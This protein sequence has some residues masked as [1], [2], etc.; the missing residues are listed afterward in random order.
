MF[1]ANTATKQPK[2]SSQKQRVFVVGGTGRTGSRLVERLRRDP[3]FDDVTVLARDKEKANNL[4]NNNNNH[5]TN[6]SATTPSSLMRNDDNNGGG[7]NTDNN[8]KTVKVV[9]GDLSNVAAWEH[10]LEGTT[11]VVTAVSSG[12]RTNPLALLGFVPLPTNL[13]KNIDCDGIGALADAAKERGVQRLVQVTTASTGTPWS[14]VAVFLN[15][16]CYMSVKWKFEGEQAVRR[17]GLDY[18][19]IRPF[20][21]TDTPRGKDTG[22]G[23]EISQGKTKGNRRRIP[24]EDVAA[25]C[26][27]ALRLE[28][29]SKMTFECWATDQHDRPLDWSKLRRDPSAVTEVNH[30]AAVA[31]ILT[32]AA[33][34]GGLLGYG[35][36]LGTRIVLRSLLRRKR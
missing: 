31:T 27:Q 1:T 4:F 3:F 16:L 20:G 24:R 14:P 9:V 30:N 33:I 12:T 21:L 36:Y 28:G 8:K 7:R 35:G 22:Y 26:H 5:K 6:G 13:S 17:S 10:N 18:V 32:G 34:T 11:H 29:E 19:V 2:N 25:L 15:A 23:V